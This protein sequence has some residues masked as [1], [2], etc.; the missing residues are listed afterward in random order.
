MTDVHPDAWCDEVGF[1]DTRV[2]AARDVGGVFYRPKTVTPHLSSMLTWR[3]VHANKEDCAAVLLKTGLPGRSSPRLWPSV[4]QHSPPGTGSVLPVFVKTGFYAVIAVLVVAPPALGDCGWYVRLLNTRPMVWLGEI[5]YEIFLVHL[6]VME[7]A[8]V[9]VLHWRVY[10]GSM[11]V[12]LMVTMVMT[13][14]VAW[15]LHRFTR[16]I[17]TSR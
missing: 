9:E 14:P 7:I 12:L 16:P 15:L 5:S 1:D 4:T 10:T 17:A 8:M 3:R 6:V 11:P 13:I 2:I